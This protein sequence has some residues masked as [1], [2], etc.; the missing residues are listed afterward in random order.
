MQISLQPLD[1]F[2]SN[3]YLWK[4]NRVSGCSVE[5]SLKS[6]DRY[7]VLLFDVG[8][9]LFKILQDKWHLFVKLGCIF[10]IFQFVYKVL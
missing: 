2:L 6:V 4:S 9:K 8:E 5:T 3:I 10:S 1:S 7:V